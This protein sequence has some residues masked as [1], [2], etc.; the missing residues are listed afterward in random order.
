MKKNIVIIVMSI[1]IIVLGTTLFL[2][3]KNDSVQKEKTST[4]EKSVKVQNIIEDEEL[5]MNQSPVTT[6]TDLMNY[7]DDVDQE[8]ETIVSKEKNTSDDEKTL[9]NTFITLTDFIFYDGTIKGKKFS[10]LTSAC[11]EKVLDLYTKI[12]SKIENKFPNYKEKI[13][14]TSKKVYNNVKEKVTDAKEKIQEEY[15]EYVG[16]E[17]YQ[18]TVDAYNEGKSDASE[19]YDTYKPYIEKGKEKVKSAYSSAKEKIAEAYQNY[20]E[21]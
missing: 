7:L 5:P 16:E 4:E 19:V 20:K 8:V 14:T 1:I 21:S 9:K 6:E 18:N 13:R 15:K 2:V 12:D 11:K 10:D 3:I 17:N